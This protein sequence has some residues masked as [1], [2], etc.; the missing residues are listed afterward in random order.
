[1]VQEKQTTFNVCYNLI[2]SE[3]REK[4][5]FGQTALEQVRKRK[6][7]LPEGQMNLGI[8][9]ALISAVANPATKI[10]LDEETH[11]NRKELRRKWDTLTLNEGT[12]DEIRM[13]G[14]FY[15]IPSDRIRPL[16]IWSSPPETR[17]GEILDS[18]R[19]YRVF[20]LKDSE[21][22]DDSQKKGWASVITLE[23]TPKG[24]K[25]KIKK[26]SNGIQDFILCKA[27][28]NDIKNPDAK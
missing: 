24:E 4:P 2:M 9:E 12:V 8:K 21:K 13:Q 3:A 17:G 5:I 14:R 6:S 23:I 10:S 15:T 26:F 7:V 25:L 19:G 1:M 18:I 20:V 22:S 16:N 27:L 28:F 11:V